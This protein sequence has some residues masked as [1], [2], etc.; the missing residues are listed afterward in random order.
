MVTSE[1]EAYSVCN[2][3]TIIDVDFGS[4]FVVGYTTESPQTC[5]RLA[6]MIEKISTTEC[7]AEVRVRPPTQDDLGPCN[8]I[9]EVSDFVAVPREGLADLPIEFA[10]P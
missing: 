9:S 3:A 4:E 7:I 6:P 8:L 10:G 2:G 1:D 5:V